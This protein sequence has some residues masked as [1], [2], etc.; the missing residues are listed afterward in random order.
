MPFVSFVVKLLESKTHYEFLFRVLAEW[1][2]NGRKRYSAEIRF[3]AY[4][5]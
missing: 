3:V 5:N 1:R 4:T 2:Q